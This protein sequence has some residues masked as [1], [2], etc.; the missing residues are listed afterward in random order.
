MGAGA[1]EEGEGGCERPDEEVDEADESDWLEGAGVVGEAVEQGERDA[2]DG[3]VREPRTCVAGL[4]HR[5][6]CSCEESDRRQAAD[7]ER[8]FLDCG[9]RLDR[10]AGAA[11]AGIDDGRD[12]ER[13]REEQQQAGERAADER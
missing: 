1:P 12:R 7:R 11:V 8:P 5:D 2:G 4:P 13:L 6:P 10:R 3:E 9:E